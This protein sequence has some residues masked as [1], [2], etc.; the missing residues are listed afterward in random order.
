[1][2]IRGIEQKLIDQMNRLAADS[3]GP[4]EKRNRAIHDPILIRKT[5]GM[6]G[7]LEA[8]ANRKLVLEIAPV[9][10]ED[11]RAIRRE[12]AKLFEKMENCRQKIFDAI[13]ALPK[14]QPVE[15]PP[16]TLNVVIDQ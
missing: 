11:I 7:R 15:F 14:M 13:P 2:R 12:L 8:T 16:I 5:D 1:M 9:T 3:K 4:S 10:V 6:A